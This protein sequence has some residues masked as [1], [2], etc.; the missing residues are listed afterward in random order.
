LAQSRCRRR[1]STR[2]G[3]GAEG[4]R[5]ARWEAMRGAMSGFY[6]ARTRGR[7]GVYIASSAFLNEK[8]RA[9]RPIPRVQL[10]NIYNGIEVI[11]LLLGLMYQTEV[12][13]TH[14]RVRGVATS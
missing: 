3:Q 9:E 2:P 7:T 11:L 13:L 12:L 5:G 6:E 4:E 1:V 14:S 8:E 10:H